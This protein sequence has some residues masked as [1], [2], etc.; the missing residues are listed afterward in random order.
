MSVRSGSLEFSIRGDELEQN[1]IQL[2]QNLQHTD[3]SL[4]LSSTPGDSDVEYPRRNPGPGPF[5]GFAS[6]DHMSRDHL[7]PEDESQYHPWSY[8]TGDDENGISPYG[9]RTIST[10]A[11]HASALTISAGLAGRGAR[12]DVSMSGAEYDP[13]RPLTG[14]IAGF[15]ADFSALDPNLTRSRHFA[16]ATVEF[17]DPLVVEDSAELDEVF[18]TGHVPLPT[19]SIR[20][21]STASNALNHVAFSPKR[22]RRPQSPIAHLP[23]PGKGRSATTRQPKAPS[24]RRHAA[25]VESDPEDDVPTPRSRSRGSYAQQSLSYAPLE[26]EVNIHPPTPPHDDMYGRFANLARGAAKDFELHTGPLAQSTARERKGTK[27]AKVPLRNVVIDLQDHNPIRAPAPRNPGVRTPYKNGKLYLPD[28]TGLTSAIG[29]PMKLGLEYKGYAGKDDREIDVRLATTLNVVQSKI[30]HL[31]TENSISRRRVRELELELEECKREVAKERTKVLEREEFDHQAPQERAARHTRAKAPKQPEPAET[32]EDIR[33]YKEAVEEKKALEALITTLRSHLTRLTSELSD[34]SRLLQELRTLRDSDVRALKEKSYE[35]N[36]LRQEVERLAGEVEVLRGVVEEGLKE[37]KEAREQSMDRSRSLDHSHSQSLIELDMRVQDGAVAG[38]H[39][40]EHLA[41]N[42]SNSGDE[43]SAGHSSP[44]PRPSPLRRHPRSADRT[45]LATV[46]SSPLDAGT[47]RRPWLESAE[48]TRISE[49]VSERRFER[50]GSASANSMVEPSFAAGRAR[51]YHTDSDGSGDDT[52]PSRPRSRGSN[53]SVRSA[54]RE[55]PARRPAAPI[56]SS[57]YSRDPATVPRAASPEH[58]PRQVPG[59]SKPTAASA[60]AAPAEAPFP[61]IRG[62]YLEKLF[63]SAPDHN[64]DT[65]TVCNRRAR[66]AATRQQR[67]A[68]WSAAQHLHH[69][70]EDEGFVEGADEG[71]AKKG[72]GRA[73]DALPPQTVLTRVLRELEDDFTHYKGIYIELADQYKDIDPVSN[74]AKRNVLAEHLREVIDVL[75]QKGDQIASLYDLLT[76]GD[77]PVREAAASGMPTS[78][79]AW[80]RSQGVR[81]QQS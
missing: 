50:S 78:T 32:D 70:A 74:V 54:G 13:D 80:V 4:H 39:G 76:Y 46:G 56:P 34:H 23:A 8:R 43:S 65:C 64:A 52:P 11:H 25:I 72:K 67:K 29:S 20:S 27:N 81:Q 40:E 18:Q 14:I 45:D 71:R 6:F 68:T 59:P 79:S 15:N 33:R 55:A 58:R 1:R 21:P 37:R 3:L 48:L 16:S 75:E 2:E 62:E 51:G 63:F 22:P 49:E 10:A 26:P 7:D 31:E 9:N 38:G 41:D 44:S 57:A 24:T 77:K 73:D 60:A 17:N 66:A 12:R 42:E 35:I 61:Q 28:V 53:T 69:A 36:Q 47:G 30:A 19:A 5:E